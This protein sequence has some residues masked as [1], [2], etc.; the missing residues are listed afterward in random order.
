V[1]NFSLIIPAF[2]ES[3]NIINLIDE[4]NSNLNEKE[5]NFE[6]IVIDD[7]S[8]DNTKNLL[9]NKK[10]LLNNLKIIT[11]Q[12]NKGQSY[13]I[14]IGIQKSTFN[15]IVTLDGDGQNDPS[16]IPRLIELYESDKNIKLVA[17]IRKKRQDT[18]IKK[19]SSL[20]ANKIRKR[21]L[22]DG[23]DDTGC[24]LKIFDKNIFLSFR[25]FNGIH[26]FLPALYNGFGYKIS[27]VNVNHRHRKYGVS[28][29]GIV[30]RLFKGIYDMI[31]V[32]FIINKKL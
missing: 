14:K 7:A 30:N 23:C 8:T 10:S 15:N 24:A 9:I 25:F 28:K 29:Y 11:N 17:G 21:V 1:F 13:S 5:Y 2:N 18:K 16:D 3:K 32:Y 6:I 31:K 19:I 20:V 4:I 26:R 12:N 22:N 27:F